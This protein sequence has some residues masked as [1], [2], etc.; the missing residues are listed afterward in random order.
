MEIRIFLRFSPFKRLF[1]GLFKGPFFSDRQKSG[2]TYPSS[3]KPSTPPPEIKE[4]KE[5]AWKKGATKKQPWEQKQNTF[6]SAKYK[7]NDVRDRN[8]C[9]SSL[10]VKVYPD[11]LL[12]L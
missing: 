8:G 5:I 1:K 12:M 3:A 4:L 10:N 2:G 11:F 7:L 6:M 9:N